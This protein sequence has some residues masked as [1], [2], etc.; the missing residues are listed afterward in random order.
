MLAGVSTVRR[1]TIRDVAE[2]AGVSV[3]TVSNAVNGRGRLPDATREH[4]KAV[5][6]ELG[7]R[8]R[9]S[10]RN[11]REGRT[12]QIGLYCSFL[13][14]IQGGLAGLG[15]YMAMVMGAAEVALGEGL[16]LMMLPTGLTAER[17]SAIDVDGL[18]VIDP[19]RDDEGVRELERL[20]LTIVT[21][22][23]DPTPGA[24]HAGCVRSDHG[25]ALRG[26][27]DHLADEAGA[28]HVALVAAG[29]E[30][31][32]TEELNASYRGWCAE[33][34]VA[35]L[36]GRVPL[37]PRPEYAADAV[38]AMLDGPQRPDA[39]V[40]A[41]DGVAPTILRLLAERGLRV[42]E[43]VRVASCVDG[44]MML[45]GT[46]PVT[47]IDLQPAAMGRALASTLAEILRGDAPDGSTDRLL[48]TALHVRS[49]TVAA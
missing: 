7:Y 28:E 29:D 33:R 6:E 14:E 23:R 19:V 18:I 2:R 48:D 36:V 20:G 39:I 9:A 38:A 32:W 12:G 4:V 49:S 37:S 24:T 41:P 31:S 1:V 8:A 21:C 35:E 10:A 22:E 40:V 16:A 11:L 30:T 47:A 42:P 27:L 17:L 26:L 13:S 34:G 25:A 46:P 45:S 3:T 43:D 44:P 15:Y 5:A